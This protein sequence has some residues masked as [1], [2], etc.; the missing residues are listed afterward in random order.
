MNPNINLK[1]R[2]ALRWTG[3][4]KRLPCLSLTPCQPFWKLQTT[5]PSDDLAPGCMC[6][7]CRN[8]FIF[9]AVL[10][11]HYVIDSALCLTKL[12]CVNTLLAV[13]VTSAVRTLS[14]CVLKCL[15][16]VWQDTFITALAPKASYHSHC[17]RVWARCLL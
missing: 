7:K 14:T 5:L 2:V 6:V 13:K 4:T 12:S 9:L 1:Y 8:C 10:H 3:S 16:I 15:W 17:R 11:C